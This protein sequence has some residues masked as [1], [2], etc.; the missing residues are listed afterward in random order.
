MT[1]KCLVVFASIIA[2]K[3][4]I[5]V[6]RKDHCFLTPEDEGVKEKWLAAIS[7]GYRARASVKVCFFYFNNSE[8]EVSSVVH[9]GVCV[10]RL[11][12]NAFP[13]HFWVIMGF[14]FGNKWVIGF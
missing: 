11:R 3:K 9:D 7:G 8:F 5:Q 13:T 4:N 1:V 10:K 6:G 14:W 12:K 2:V